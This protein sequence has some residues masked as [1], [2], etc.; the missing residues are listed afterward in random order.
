MHRSQPPIWCNRCVCIWSDGNEQ[1]LL[2][3][4]FDPDFATNGAFYVNYTDTDG[5]TQI[6]RFTASGGAAD[7]ASAE[8]ILSVEQPQSNHNG[9]W[10]AFGPNP[11]L[12]NVLQVAIAVLVLLIAIQLVRSLMP[13]L[14]GRASLRFDALWEPRDVLA[15]LAMSDPSP[16]VRATAC[17]RSCSTMRMSTPRS[18][19]IATSVAR[20]IAELI[21]VSSRSA[22]ASSTSWK[23]WSR[24]TLNRPDRIR[25]ASERCSAPS[26]STGDAS[27][28]TPWPVTTSSSWTR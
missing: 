9:G 19:M 4:A 5:N 12:T 1:G 8:T 17:P 28:S 27:P 13:F 24:V 11:A 14:R 21:Q 7:P 2:G 10:L 26:C 6:V 22:Q 23:A 25:R 3:L 15:K 18:A 20:S 16:V